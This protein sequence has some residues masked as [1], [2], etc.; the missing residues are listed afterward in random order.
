LAFSRAIEAPRLTTRGIHGQVQ[1]AL[2]KGKGD[3]N[4]L[5][6]T[7]DTW[8]VRLTPE[9]VRPRHFSDSERC[10]AW[11]GRLAIAAA[12][13]VRAL[14]AGSD[15]RPSMVGPSPVVRARCPLRDYLGAG[16]LAGAKPPAGSPRARF[17]Q[18][19]RGDAGVG[20]AVR[21]AGAAPG[22]VVDAGEGSPRIS[23]LLLA[24]PN[25][26]SASSATSWSSCAVKALASR[27]RTFS[28]KGT[29][30][31]DVHL[32]RLF[33]VASSSRRR[34][35]P[36]QDSLDVPFR[37]IRGCLAELV[38]PFSRHL[39][40]VF[41]PFG[42]GGRVRVRGLV[43]TLEARQ[44][45]LPQDPEL[46]GELTPLLVVERDQKRVASADLG[47]D[48]RDVTEVLSDLGGTFDILFGGVFAVARSESN[49][50]SSGRT[51]SDNARWSRWSVSTIGPSEAS[52][53]GVR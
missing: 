40:H 51:R 42:S 6:R 50:R 17:G 32:D 9:S 10:K 23:G 39:C 4:S 24:E 18:P 30:R 49:V 3:I 52:C 46:P 33:G 15:D 27:A 8:V 20:Q 19:D 53:S 48:N 2:D 22:V 38:E 12:T 1:H 28:K 14:K 47:V 7:A 21:G 36:G 5:L 25:P 37:P 13:I 43:Q 45:R 31:R 41:R 29:H 26:N 44:V 34:R 16:F 11:I 35:R